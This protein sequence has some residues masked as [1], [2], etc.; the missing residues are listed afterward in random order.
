VL[1]FKVIYIGVKFDD[2]GFIYD[3]L[4][5]PQTYVNVVFYSEPFYVQ[6]TLNEVLATDFS[7]GLGH[8]MEIVYLVIPLSTEFG[9]KPVSFNDLFQL[10]LFPQ[11][12]SYGLANNIW[13]QMWSA[14]G[15]VLLIL[16]VL[17]FCAA[18]AAGE[19]ARRKVG[20]EVHAIIVVALAYWCFYIHRNDLLGALQFER[21]ILLVSLGAYMIS[22][23][24]AAVMRRRNAARRH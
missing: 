5:D 23:L 17:V 2:Y 15:W 11:A 18:I 10:A 13:A 4:A 19:A 1:T 8:L 16:F 21:Y 22:R 3:K 20:P 14:G 7:V 24:L 9:I 6:S 12:L